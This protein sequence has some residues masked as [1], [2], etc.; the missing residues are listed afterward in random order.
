[1]TVKKCM[2]FPQPKSA[3]C[4]PGPAGARQSNQLVSNESEDVLPEALVDSLLLYLL[5]KLLIILVSYW[6]CGDF[7]NSKLCSE[8]MP[9]FAIHCK[10]GVAIKEKEMSLVHNLPSSRTTSVLSRRLSPRPSPSL[11]LYVEYL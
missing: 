5:H 8:V 1:M 10:C 9:S 6:A 11:R 2:G 3:I 4:Q 7:G